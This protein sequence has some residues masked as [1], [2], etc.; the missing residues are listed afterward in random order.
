MPSNDSEAQ[1]R[2][3]L[4]ELGRTGRLVATNLAA[5]KRTSLLCAHAKMRRWPETSDTRAAIST[6]HGV[7][8]VQA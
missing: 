1:F 6:C 7:T 4:V 2:K 3:F 8:E 5:Y